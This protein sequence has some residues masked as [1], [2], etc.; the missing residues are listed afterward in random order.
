[1]WSAL[2]KHEKE[3]EN[4]KRYSCPECSATFNLKKN[5]TLHIA[6]H[7]T[8]NFECPECGATNFKRL[9]SFKSH[10]AVHQ[11][12]DNLA[13]PECEMEFTNEARLDEHMMN[14]HNSKTEILVKKC[15]SK[16]TNLELGKTSKVVPKI[17][18]RYGPSVVPSK[19]TLSTEKGAMKNLSS[20]LLS[21]NRNVRQSLLLSP[22]KVFHQKC[23]SFR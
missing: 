3:H 12:E 19:E 9:A 6:S 5:L 16:S 4:D 7:K 11:E 14:E 10:L 21:K 13:C 15:G 8:S 23:S 22:K 20:K 18:I 2:K 17:K 1:M